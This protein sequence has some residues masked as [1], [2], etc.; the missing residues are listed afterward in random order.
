MRKVQ[1][2]DINLSKTGVEGKTRSMT[3][4]EIVQDLLQRLPD[5]VSL[6]DIAEELRFI[7]A[8]RQ[9]ISELDRGE[10]IPIEEVEACLS[11]WIQSAQRQRRGI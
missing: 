7:A 4:K 11:S 10:S 1:N 3:N 2:T 6:E 9:G 5:D 8:V